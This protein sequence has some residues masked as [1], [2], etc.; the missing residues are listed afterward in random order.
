MFFCGGGG[1]GFCVE[2]GKER[3]GDGGEMGGRWEGHDGRD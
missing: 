2:V 3:E 1:L